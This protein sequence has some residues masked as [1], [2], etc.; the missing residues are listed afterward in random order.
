MPCWHRVHVGPVLLAFVVHRCADMW[1]GV[2][3]TSDGPAGLPQH[4]QS[5][6]DQRT[7]CMTHQ[8]LMA[9]TWMP[10]QGSS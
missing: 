8:L 3:R 7:N 1:I 10:R 2:R 6:K 5:S 9:C 4:L